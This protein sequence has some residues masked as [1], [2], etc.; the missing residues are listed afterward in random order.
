MT[1]RIISFDRILGAFEWVN[2]ELDSE[3]FV[4]VVRGRLMQTMIIEII[5]KGAKVLIKHSSA[6]H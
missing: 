1:D 3:D 5:S 6:L 2:F 4:R